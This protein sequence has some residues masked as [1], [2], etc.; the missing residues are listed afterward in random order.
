MTEA[1]HILGVRHHGPGSARAVKRTLEILRPDIIL[2][3]GPP[4]AEELLALAA[5]DGMKP[6][7]A[8]LLYQPD[9]P[10][11]AVY[12]PFAVF[13]PE[14]QAIQF[15]LK[16]KVPI[17]FMDLPQRHRLAIEAEQK[18]KA[19]SAKPDEENDAA[20]AAPGAEPTPAPGEPETARVDPF[21][22]IAQAAGYDDSERW[23]E[24]HIE[25]RREGPEI[26][27][28]VLELM[29]AL[30]ESVDAPHDEW[31]TRREAFMRQTLREAQKEG[32][33]NIAVVCGAW[34][35]PALATLPPAKQ[36][37]E[38]LKG[39]PK[40]AV[41]ATWV[42]W[43]HGRLA[44]FSGYGAGVESPGYY[45]HLWTVERAEEV[46][47]RWLTRVAHVLRDEDLECSTASVI[48]A[49][50]LAESAARLRGRV[51]P[52]LQE[53][54][55]ATR[56]VFCFGGDAPLRLVEQRLIV[57]E[58]L[59]TV[60]E[61]APTVPLQRDLQAQ[62][63]RLRL[64]PEAL[65]RKLELD[66]R[67]ETDLDRSR[68]LHRLLLLAV[69]WGK[70]DR[71]SRS[72][73]T[74]REAWAL[75]WE[76]EFQ[77]RLIENAPWGN[78]VEEAAGRRTLDRAAKAAGLP[79]LTALVETLLLADLPAAVEQVMQ[80]VQSAAALTTDVTHLMDALPPLAGVLRYGNVR[81]TDAA[82][83]GNVVEGLVTRICIGAPPACASLSDEAALEMLARLNATH[84]AIATLERAELRE[85]WLATVRTLAADET[86]H[87]LIGGRSHRILFDEHEL[88][89][90]GLARS[91]SR[92]LS[93]ASAPNHAAAW[94]EGF[95]RGSG[96]LLLHQP[97]LWALLDAWI[98]GLSADHFTAV[99]P[100]L[101]RTF[102]TFPAP[103]RRQLGELARRGA[104]DAVV[105]SQT[106]E[107][108]EDVDEERANRVLP[109]LKLIFSVSAKP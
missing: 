35:A 94:L 101:R 70:P 21:R 108:D 51:V 74:F 6:P 89:A 109:I 24:E 4:E 84:S 107:S 95:L 71:A 13:S 23:W 29:T 9:S 56:A 46:G 27:K 15:G 77:V 105:L 44:Y 73:G 2:L 97:Q 83:V 48:E 104:A 39:L 81:Q 93:R 42:P 72:K 31:E 85:L 5:H 47:M 65:D 14:W 96:L 12:Y 7:V 20:G 26:F 40:I 100:L 86:L 49:T 1:I 99:V 50:R 68:L 106:G 91:L 82:M 67:K 52:G 11:H 60:P 59:G 103:E 61:A 18:A 62:Q 87:G 92:S 80:R 41:A 58:L 57:G 88:D 45:E 79:D 25:K 55:E 75:R 17:R 98:S 69:P 33:K 3:E 38:A 19:D 78:T 43:T 53:F 102:A 16:Q 76:P 28:A 36:D 8:L 66:L 37:A 34:H 30:R 32:F 22:L 63:K 10:R 54:N 90:P 64:P